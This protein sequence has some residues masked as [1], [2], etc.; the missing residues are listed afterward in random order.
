MKKKKKK[1]NYE[2]EELRKGNVYDQVKSEQY[3]SITIL[4]L[5]IIK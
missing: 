5:T 3:C 4:F 2:E 1:K